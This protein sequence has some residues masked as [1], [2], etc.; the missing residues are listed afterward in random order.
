MTKP[1]PFGVGE[2]AFM[3][4]C[5]RLCRLLLGPFST[6]SA[7]LVMALMSE[8]ATVMAATVEYLKP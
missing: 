6:I 3:D 8:M 1:V 2:H 5:F 4:R 7:L